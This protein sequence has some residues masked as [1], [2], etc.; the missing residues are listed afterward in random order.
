MWKSDVASLRYLA[1]G[2]ANE[3]CGAEDVGSSGTWPSVASL[4]LATEN[5][6]AAEGTKDHN[7]IRHSTT[8]HNNKTQH[9]T[10]Q[11]NTTQHSTMQPNTT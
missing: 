11:R 1:W 7:T 6:V 3:F 4:R 5:C 8:K 10:P 2:G 9:S